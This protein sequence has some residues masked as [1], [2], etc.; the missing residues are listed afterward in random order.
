MRTIDDHRTRVLLYNR[1]VQLGHVTAFT[2]SLSFTELIA[3]L[4]YHCHE[5]P[6]EHAKDAKCLFQPSYYERI[7]LT[8]AWEIVEFVD[9]HYPSASHFIRTEVLL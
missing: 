6:Y 7:G 2:Q 9:T 1:A 5:L 8:E 4:C 3:D